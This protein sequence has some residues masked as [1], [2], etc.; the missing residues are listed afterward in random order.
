ML[1]IK[2]SLDLFVIGKTGADRELLVGWCVRIKDIHNKNTVVRSSMVRRLCVMSRFSLRRCV[3]KAPLGH[4]KA[5]ST[6]N[7]S[8]HAHWDG[9]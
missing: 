6:V 7:G 8:L 9:S 4:D 3:R 5:C 1:F 2:P